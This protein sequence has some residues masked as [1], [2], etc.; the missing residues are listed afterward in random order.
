[1]DWISPKAGP[2]TRTQMERIYFGVIPRN[3]Q[4]TQDTEKLKG[5]LGEGLLI[6]KEILTLSSLLPR[7][8]GALIALG[9]Y[10][11]V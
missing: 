9:N 11:P 4:E 10:K 3:T 8:T 6:S 5:N 2:E 1:M 7:V